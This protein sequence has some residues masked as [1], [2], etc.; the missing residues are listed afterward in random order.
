[1]QAPAASGVYEIGYIRG[2]RFTRLYGGESEVSIRVRLREHY[3]QRGNKDI[4]ERVA[5]GE[6]LRCHWKLT[7]NPLCVEAKLQQRYRY[8][9]NKKQESVKTR[10]YKK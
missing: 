2:Q 6:T 8:P 4:G 3:K 1:M 5:R 7:E 9:D 10:C